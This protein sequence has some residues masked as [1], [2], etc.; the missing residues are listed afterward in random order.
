MWRHVVSRSVCEVALDTATAEPDRDVTEATALANDADVDGE[1][2]ATGF[3]AAAPDGTS[4]QGELASAA[5]NGT[6]AGGD[7][8]YGAGDSCL[9]WGNVTG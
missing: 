8:I 6:L 3:S 1:G 2:E 4:L 9:F 7:G 5:K